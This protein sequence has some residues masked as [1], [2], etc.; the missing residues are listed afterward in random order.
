VVINQKNFKTGVLHGE[1]LGFWKKGLV[2]RRTIY[3]KGKLESLERYQIKYI[4]EKDTTIHY[5]SE[6]YLGEELINHGVWEVYYDNGQIRKSSEFKNGVPTGE[7]KGWY[8]NGQLKYF[9]V[10]S[11]ETIVFFEEYDEKGNVK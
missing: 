1:S 6:S 9:M 11:E 3:N 4:E 8:E 2:S 5:L 10:Y 7:W